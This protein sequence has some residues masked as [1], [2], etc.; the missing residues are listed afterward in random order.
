MLNIGTPELL[1]V[2]IIAL[3]VVGPER[4]PEL[5]R[6]VGRG[7]RELR[8]VQAEVRDMV[9]TGLPDEFR[10]AA[11]EMRGAVNEMRKT[12]DEVMRSADVRGA[13]HQEPHKDRAAA[14]PDASEPVPDESEPAAEPVPEESPSDPPAGE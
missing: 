11:D 1:V 10:E 8:K 7:F 14:E 5:A 13:F 9:Q 2:L 4:L 3:V 12:A 6:W